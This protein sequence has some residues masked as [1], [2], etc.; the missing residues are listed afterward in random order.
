MPST[1]KS[2]EYLKS[3]SIVGVKG[4]PF[5]P[6]TPL[7]KLS[8]SVPAGAVVL[9]GPN[10]SGKTT[11]FERSSLVPADKGSGSIPEM[12]IQTRQLDSSSIAA[13]YSRRAPSRHGMPTLMP[14][15]KNAQPI[16]RKAP[17]GLVILSL[18]GSSVT[19]WIASLS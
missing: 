15:N 3:G 6:V 14:I 19:M 2:I 9:L 8:V 11:S 17:T 1:R 10:G 16:R 12:D 13:T 4:V 7:G 5:G 18:G